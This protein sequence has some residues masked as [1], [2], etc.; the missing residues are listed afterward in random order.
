MSDCIFCK[1]ASGEMDTKLLYE[2]E[3]VVVFSDID[4]QAPVH[5]LIIPKK[6]ISTLLDISAED[7]DLIGYIYMI[8]AKLARENG[9]AEDGFRVVSNCNEDGGQSVYHIHFH[10]LGGRSMQWPPG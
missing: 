8:A 4:P 3:R 6:H 1:I 2:D 10:L 7:Q 9:I 5:L